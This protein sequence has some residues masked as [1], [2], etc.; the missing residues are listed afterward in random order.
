MEREIWKF[1]DEDVFSGIPRNGKCAAGREGDLADIFEECIHAGFQKR[2]IE[3]RNYQEY[4]WDETSP[5]ASPM[6]P[7]RAKALPG[8]I[9]GSIGREIERKMDQTEGAFYIGRLPPAKS[10]LIGSYTTLGDP[11][12]VEKKMYMDYFRE[13]CSKIPHLEDAEKSIRQLSTYVRHPLSEL[14]HM[15][16]HVLLAVFSVVQVVM[17]ANELPGYDGFLQVTS[18]PLFYTSGETG[19]LFWNGLGWFVL[20]LLPLLIM[21]WY[22]AEG[23]EQLG[24]MAGVL[25]TGHFVV[26][27]GHGISALRIP[28]ISPCVAALLMVVEAA[29]LLVY[30]VAFFK[31]LGSFFKRISRKKRIPADYEP[32]FVMDAARCYRNCR[33]HILW[34]ENATGEKAPF[35]F[36]SAISTLEKLDKKYCKLL[37]VFER[38]TA[39]RK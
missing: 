30:V 9:A 12:H 33:L 19:F 13:G 37:P 3:D 34:Y 29:F 38:L 32:G 21:G 39:S 15:I 18:L 27:A 10:V 22:E 20:G 5:N 16:V 2:E 23:Q 7:T 26:A 17:A 36:Y 4:L 24:N 1:Q 14:L 8:E 35:Q 31:L 28:F 6:P 25:F 11:R